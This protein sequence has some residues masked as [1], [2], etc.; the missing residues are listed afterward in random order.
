[1]STTST[2]SSAHAYHLLFEPPLTWCAAG[3]R[4]Y[5]KSRN[6]R[7]QVQTKLDFQHLS[8]S[9]HKIF[10][11]FCASRSSSSSCSHFQTLWH[12]LAA[13]LTFIDQCH[14]PVL[15]ANSRESASLNQKNSSW[16]LSQKCWR[17]CNLGSAWSFLFEKLKQGVCPNI[18]KC[19]RQVRKDKSKAKQTSSLSRLT[20]RVTALLWPCSLRIPWTTHLLR[21]K[22]PLTHSGL[23]DRDQWL[24]NLTPES[25]DI[26]SVTFR[27][28]IFL[29]LTD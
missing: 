1:M 20:C 9:Y 14:R 22:R 18:I 17:I 3:S 2:G 25:F 16:L 24:S 13:L 6:I 26:L 21:K 5:R 11:A 28:S 19:V 15:E 8:T 4:S 10:Q 29:S 27:N 23:G 7:N 12:A